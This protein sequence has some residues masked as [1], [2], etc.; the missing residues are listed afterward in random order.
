MK[1]ESQLPVNQITCDT[2][3]KWNKGNS[4]L[5][6]NQVIHNS[7]VYQ[8][9]Q[10]IIAN[11][12]WNV[13]NWE[14]VV[15][16]GN[17]FSI[18][19]MGGK[20]VSNWTLNVTCTDSP[21]GVKFAVTPEN[22]PMPLALWG[23]SMVPDMNGKPVELLSGAVI[24]SLA[25]QPPGA[26]EEVNADEFTFQDVVENDPYWQWENEYTVVPKNPIPKNPLVHRLLC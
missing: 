22:K 16:Q 2:I 23:D 13:V 14:K 5:K 26:T 17:S 9:K 12:A 19:P 21:S 24:R 6:G 4:Y 3:P 8:A 1:V 15:L 11:T 10:D 20:Q 7:Q 25:S 18:A